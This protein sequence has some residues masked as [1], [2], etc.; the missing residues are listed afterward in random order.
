MTENRRSI[1]TDLQVRP[2]DCGR[3]PPPAET[4]HEGL[5]REG[6]L[7]IDR[8][9]PES[10]LGRIAFGLLPAVLVPECDARSLRR[11]EERMK[12]QSRWHR[13][14]AVVAQSDPGEEAVTLNCVS[15][16]GLEGPGPV[17]I[18]LICQ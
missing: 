7:E 12:P 3:A 13:L 2:L 17:V 16:P 11:A 14:S 9:L 6:L 8:I 1:E 15:Q 18:G 10:G 5:I 4:A